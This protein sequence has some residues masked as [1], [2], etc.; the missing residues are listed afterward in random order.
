[1]VLMTG[2]Y[3][4]DV[5]FSGHGAGGSPTAVAVVSDLCALASGTAPAAVEAAPSTVT[6]EFE[7]RH[8]VRFIVKDRPGIVA[9]IAGAMAAESIN[10]DS[11]FQRSGFGKD[12]LPFVVTTEP[13]ANSRLKRAL[14]KMQ[15][16]D[17]QARPPLDF[18]ILEPEPGIVA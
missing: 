2:Q 13:C 9:E 14:A 4:G 6:G 17:W 1:M 11:L 10:I 16:A 3:G 15:S 7:L 8:Y 18:Q 12:N 5:V